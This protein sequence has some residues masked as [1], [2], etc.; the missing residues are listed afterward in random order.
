MNTSIVIVNYKGHIDTIECL[1]SVLN[2]DSEN[3]NI[4][5]VDNSPTNESFEYI[6][7]W[8]NV[9]ISVPTL[10]EVEISSDEKSVINFSVHYESDEDFY[11]KKISNE[12]LFKHIYLIKANNNNGFAAANNVGTTFLL[13]NCESSLFWFL[14]NDTVI[15]KNAIKEI[16]SFMNSHP[17]I[18]LAGTSLYEYTKPNILQY[19]GGKY[20]SFVA[21]DFPISKGKMDFEVTDSDLKSIDFPPGASMLVTKQFVE[22]VGLMN[23]DYFLFF[24]EIDWAVRGKKKGFDMGCILQSKVWHKGSCSINAGSEKNVKT[25]ICDYFGLRSRLLFTIKYYPAKLPF[26]YLSSVLFILNRLRRKQFDRISVLMKICLNPK[27]SIKELI[28]KL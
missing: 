5:V 18:G 10:D 16:V 9:P 27:I 14:N 23:P 26:V 15:H 25:K 2:L 1:Q 17:K 20:K 12:F 7:N 4:V 21:I 8:L 3:Y 11:N 22:S 13:N 28:S 24:E 6:L 19:L